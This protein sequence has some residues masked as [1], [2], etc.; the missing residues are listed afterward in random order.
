[1]ENAEGPTSRGPT[2]CVLFRHRVKT[3]KMTSAVG[4]ERGDIEI[5]E[6]IVLP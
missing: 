4:N 1:M 2:C 6:Y 5:D 3:H